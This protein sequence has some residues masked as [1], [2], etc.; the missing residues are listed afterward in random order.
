[1]LDV[2]STPSVCLE[3]T[4]ESKVFGTDMEPAQ[5]ISARVD[6]GQESRHDL[7]SGDSVRREAEPSL[8]AKSLAF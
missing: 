7:S 8:T 6:P 1:M 5:F 2:S 3:L 4:D